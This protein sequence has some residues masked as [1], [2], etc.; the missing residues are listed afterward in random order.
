MGHGTF[1]A[2]VIGA[3]N[4]RF[5]VIG[6]APGTPLWSVRVVDDAGLIS[7]ESLI[8]AID[9]V[10]STHK[11]DDESND[12]AVANI[13]IAG[14]GRRHAQ[15]RQGHGPDALRHLPLGPGRRHLRSRGRQ[16]R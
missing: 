12:I 14:G 6:T 1:V 11:D 16:R 4:N 5:G 8:C 3:R 10:T 9:W 7:E 13:S 2:G 15:L